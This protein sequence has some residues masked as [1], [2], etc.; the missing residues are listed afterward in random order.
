MSNKEFWRRKL[1]SRKLWIAVAG[2]VSGVIT[3]A[4]GDASRAELIAGLILQFASVVGYLLAEG[5]T[6]YAGVT[7]QHEK[8][9]ETDE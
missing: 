9:D 1:T 7:G 3:A 6:D 8:K 2:F 4:G 5:L